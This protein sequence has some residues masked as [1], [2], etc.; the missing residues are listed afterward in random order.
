MQ[1]VNSGHGEWLKKSK[2]GTE[3]AIAP[4][5]SSTVIF[6]GATLSAMSLRGIAVTLACSAV[7]ASLE[8]L[9][10]V[11]LDEEARKVEH[12]TKEPRE[13][14]D[15]VR[16]EKVENVEGLIRKS[17]GFL[18]LNL[19]NPKGESFDI[20]GIGCGGEG[21]STAVCLKEKLT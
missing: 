11:N 1:E 17:R 8:T 19:S 18:P 14:V 10:T 4:T 5:T 21:R 6:R 16:V 13:D 15:G 20:E 2:L 9:A 12:W 7:A 3:G